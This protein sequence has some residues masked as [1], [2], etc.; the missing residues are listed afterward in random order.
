MSDGILL[1]VHPSFKNLTGR[2]FGRLVVKSYF[3]RTNAKRTH[4]WTCEC[5]CGETKVV[6]GHHL[7]SGGVTS[8]GCWRASHG[9]THGMSRQ[10]EYAVWCCMLQRCGNGNNPSYNNYGGRGI[11]VCQRWHKFENFYADMG[12][13][14]GGCYELDRRDNDGNYEPSN[15]WWIKRERQAVNRRSNRVLKCRGETLCIADWASRL[16]ISASR[17]SRRL[18]LGWDTEAALFTPKKRTPRPIAAIGARP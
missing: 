10:P 7:T 6:S 12:P 4:A 14:P 17:I 11:T 5:E 15:C 16:G 2:T 8:C 13:R 3:G 1:P 9:R 18:A